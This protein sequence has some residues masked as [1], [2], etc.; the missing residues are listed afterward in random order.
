MSGSDGPDHEPGDEVARHR[1]TI[2]RLDRDL[3]RLLAERMAAAR[4]VGDHRSRDKDAAL[5]DDDRERR[6]FEAWGR[7][8]ESRGI[9]AYFARRVLREVLNWSRRDQ[10]RFLGSAATG[11]GGARSAR[12]GYQG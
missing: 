4:A 7:E 6:L 5:R 9:S 8:A 12:V 2:D 11:P 3:I 10:E 1:E